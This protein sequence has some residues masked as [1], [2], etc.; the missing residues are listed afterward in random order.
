MTILSNSEQINQIY[1]LPGLDVEESA[2]G[3]DYEQVQFTFKDNMHCGHGNYEVV[4]DMLN[5]IV[6]HQIEGQDFDIEHIM[7]NGEE[8]VVFGNIGA[9]TGTVSLKG[10]KVNKIIVE[11]HP[12]REDKCWKFS[13][14]NGLRFLTLDKE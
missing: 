2:Q 8:F 11:S 14:K 5:F 3:H 10:G 13:T 12:A 1:A 7:D 4:G 6:C 9:L